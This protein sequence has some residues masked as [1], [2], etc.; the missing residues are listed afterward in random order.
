MAEFASV[1]LSAEMRSARIPFGDKAFCRIIVGVSRD[2]SAINS[3]GCV[4]VIFL[5]MAVAQSMLGQTGT[6]T[7]TAPSN[8]ATGPSADVIE[9]FQSQM[10]DLRQQADQLSERARAAQ[11]ALRSIKLQMANMGLDMRLDVREVEARMTYLADKIRSEI[12]AGDAVSAEA[13]LRM[14]GYAADLIERFLG[15]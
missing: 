15:R 10:R 3:L 13:H 2:R 14:A 1:F 4:A 8:P 5:S 6:Q 12:E 7:P 11:E 9:S